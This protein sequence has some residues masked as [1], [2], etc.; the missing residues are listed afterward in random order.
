[1][2][3][4]SSSAKQRVDEALRTASGRSFEGEK[5]MKVELREHWDAERAVSRLPFSM[6][7]HIFN[8]S[9]LFGG[10]SSE[11]EGFH[12]TLLSPKKWSNP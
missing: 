5:R 10:A 7:L 11:F 12:V 1:M 4:Q 2:E 9:A 6:V 3:V 8:R